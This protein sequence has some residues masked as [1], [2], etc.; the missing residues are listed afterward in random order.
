M[1]CEDLV[2]GVRGEMGRGE[3]QEGRNVCSLIGNACSYIAEM[4]TL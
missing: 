4:K 1:L 2:G 3:S